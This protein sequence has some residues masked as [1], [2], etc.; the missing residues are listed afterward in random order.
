VARI[1]ALTGAVPALLTGDNARAATSLAG[2]AGITDVRADLLPADKV[3]AVHNLQADGQHVLLVGDGV[4]D[5]PALAAATSAVAKGRAGS[6]LALDT[7]DAVIMR[8]DLATIRAVIGLSRCARRPVR[9][10]LAIAA[11]FITVLVVWDLLGHLPSSSAYSDTKAPSS[12]SDSTDYAYYA[13]RP[14]AGR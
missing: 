13:A 9:T 7:A 8:D 11:T 4:N 1:T 3:Q 5:A 14:G 6:D 10:N 2:Q 12:S